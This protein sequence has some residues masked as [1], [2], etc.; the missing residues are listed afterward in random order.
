M[1]PPV[2][3]PTVTVVVTCHDHGRFLSDAVE[4][5]RNQTFADL[6]V[7]VVDDGSTDH[8]PAVAARL[9]GIRYIR[10]KRAGLSAARNTGWRAGLGCYVSFLDA[11]DRLLPQ[12]LETGVAWATAHPNAAFVSG[13]YV[14][15]DG[16]GVRVSARRRPCVTSEHYEALLRSNYIGMHA[17]V[18]YRRETLERHGGFDV[19]LRAAEDYDMYFRAA[20]QTPIVCHPEVVAEYRWH[21]ANM[22]LD[23]GL[24]LSGTL[25]VLGRQREYVREDARLKQ[26]YRDGLRFW[27][28]LFGEALLDEVRD[29]MRTA[30]S[31]R[32]TVR[33]VMLLIRFYPLGLARRT[34]RFTK[35]MVRRRVGF[36]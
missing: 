33:P 10:Q 3:A 4:S 9:G 34:L 7:I 18:L 19:S 28:H 35:R 26:A 21:G 1:S 27:Q 22:S 8:T 16:S 25:R 23:S 12:A 13:H 30:K 24:M 20:R 29:R 2:G 36:R 15:I 14:I 11:D 5:V 6:E 31:W 32:A 17:T